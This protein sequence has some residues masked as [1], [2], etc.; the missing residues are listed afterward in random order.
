MDQ[1]SLTETKDGKH[2]RQLVVG[3]SWVSPKSAKLIWWCLMGANENWDECYSGLYCDCEEK[4]CQLYMCSHKRQENDVCEMN[5][6]E[7]FVRSRKEMFD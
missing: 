3:G 5:I 7:S 1:N 4:F 2:R 6:L